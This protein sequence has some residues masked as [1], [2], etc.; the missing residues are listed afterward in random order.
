M[1]IIN[2]E[3]TGF[4]DWLSFGFALVFCCALGLSS[5]LLLFYRR[6]VPL[7]AK[8]I[9]NLLIVIYA[10]I[11][12]IIGTFIANEHLEFIKKINYT[13]CILG[14]VFV[15]YALGLGPWFAAIIYRCMSYGFIFKNEKTE[16]TE[17]D[18]FKRIL[19]ID[20]LITI[21][22]CPILIICLISW[23]IGGIQFNYTLQT[24]TTHESWKIVILVWIS[25]NIL[26][27]LTLIP[28]IKRLVD[29]TFLNEGK[30]LLIIIGSGFIALCICGYFVFTDSLNYR[31]SRCIFLFVIILLHMI[32]FIQLIAPS[33]YRA[34]VYDVNYL[35]R[36]GKSISPENDIAMIK[37]LNDIEQIDLMWA[38]F[39]DWCSKKNIPKDVII[40]QSILGNFN[41]KN[42]VEFIMLVDYY[43]MTFK[44]KKE[45]TTGTHD[46]IMTVYVHGVDKRICFPYEIMEEIQIKGN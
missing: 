19:Y 39:L 42:A 28:I 7:K 43:K 6:Y 13:S 25:I 37:S 30:S 23:L 21:T 18:N 45:N 3:P 1:T 29:N 31:V 14:T 15:Q 35:I 34:S 41:T 10:G 36:F 2:R 32:V 11:F 46:S 9:G 24:C 12:H 5:T 4:L 8:N 27:L 38:D 20:S 40:N 33:I 16:K 17:N 26:V 44:F 22:Y